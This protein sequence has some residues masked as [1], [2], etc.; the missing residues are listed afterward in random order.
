MA[1]PNRNLVR[2][3]IYWLP[4]RMEHHT[5]LLSFRELG[6]LLDAAGFDVVERYTSLNA[7]L[8]RRCRTSLGP[9]QTYVARKRDV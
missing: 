2:R 8:N 1:T 5:N 9:E 3:L 4:D 6:R 7:L